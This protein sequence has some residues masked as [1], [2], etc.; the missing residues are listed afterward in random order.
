[1]SNLCSKR[2]LGAVFADLSPEYDCSGMNSGDINKRDSAIVKQWLQ[3]SRLGRSDR[4]ANKGAVKAKSQQF[5][6]KL[7]F[8]SVPLCDVNVLKILNRSLK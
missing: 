1:M 8:S 2:A 3:C 5:C 6:I 7:S 4:M